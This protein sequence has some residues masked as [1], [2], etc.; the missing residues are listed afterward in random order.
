MQL[1]TKKL[2]YFATSVVILVVGITLSAQQV[3]P[4]V[5]E[6]ISPWR[7]VNSLA[8]EPAQPLAVPALL[9]NAIIWRPLGSSELVYSHLDRSQTRRYDWLRGLPL[10]WQ[11]QH[12]ET[13][14]FL[15]WLTESETLWTAI[16]SA[17]G[18]QI[19]APIEIASQ[20]VSDF[21]TVITEQDA[22]VVF[23]TADDALGMRLVDR[24]G[25][26]LVNNLLPD[27]KHFAVRKT[28]GQHLQIAW[29]NG[30]GVLQL[31]EIDLKGDLLTEAITNTTTLNAFSLPLLGEGWLSS[32][33]LLTVE[34]TSIVIWGITAAQQPDQERYS[35]ATITPGSTEY[36]SLSLGDDVSLRWARSHSTRPQLAIAANIGN[37][38]QPTLITFDT[39]GAF[40]VQTVE[41]AE[42]TASSIAA[43]DEH[44]AWVTLDSLAAPQL[45]VTTLDERYGNVQTATRDV[46]WQT[47]IQEGLATGYLAILWLILPIGLFLRLGGEMKV[48]AGAQLAYWL[49]KTVLPLGVFSMYPL[50]LDGLGIASPFVLTS[51]ALLAINAC[52]ALIAYTSLDKIPITLKHA[53]YFLTD[54]LLTFAIFAYG[55]DNVDFL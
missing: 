5:V 55:V 27:V 7:I 13:E 38:W 45:Y 6:T 23:W 48:F 17:E 31:G 54:A 47:A 33:E 46:A 39:H 29:V 2:S 43:Y 24:R 52:A 21:Q 15:S 16:L 37:Q 25:P 26:R 40:N 28:S 11:A 35:L 9:D 4:K 10:R 44:I 22:L 20:N 18:E 30:E 8:P 34:D 49:A 53:T 41:G 1:L 51:L 14:I 12:S 50:A 19:T 36:A 32:L 42:V 3:P